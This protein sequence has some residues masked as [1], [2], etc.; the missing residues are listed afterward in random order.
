M[1]IQILYH[2]LLN[3]DRNALSKAITLAESNRPED[4]IEAK[5]LMN[6]V[7]QSSQTSFRI[8]VTGTPGAGKSTFI[9]ALG[10]NFI[11]QGY[12][13]AVL[14]ID[15]GSSIS[16]GSIL[17]DK[18]R[19]EE[20]AKQK[21]VFIRPTAATDYLGGVHSSTQKLV[22][23]CEAAGYQRIIIESVG[24]GQSEHHISLL[25]D[26]S[27]LLLAPAGGDD[28]QGIKRGV[29]EWADLILINKA[30]GE[31]KAKAKL[32]AGYIYSILELLPK[33]SEWNV[34]VLSCSSVT[35]EGL[36]EVYDEVD[37]FYKWISKKPIDE[38]RQAQAAQRWQELWPS[39]CAQYLKQDPDIQSYSKKLTDQL[40]NGEISEFTADDCMIRFIFA[41]EIKQ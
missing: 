21:E 25:S 36:R 15:P 2:Q 27:M 17:G 20:L 18:T 14:S 41:R 1:D 10:M 13:V 5:Q 40:K 24:V 22:S 9:N 19:M 32:A 4:K 29:M 6:L 31:L 7:Q 37:Q 34:K 8:G 26:M 28:L 39:T 11:R 16:K 23:L 38:L 33:K 12:K 35:Q 3:G 30:D